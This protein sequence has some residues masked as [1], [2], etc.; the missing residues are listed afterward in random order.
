M[1]DISDDIRTSEPRLGEGEEDNSKANIFEQIIKSF[2]Y[3]RPYTSGLDLKNVTF[4]SSQGF[5]FL[6][7][8]IAD[9]NF[10]EDINYSLVSGLLFDELQDDFLKVLDKTYLE[11]KNST[12]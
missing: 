9:I 7:E 1:K 3:K 2:N 8:K 6:C 10:R 11:L 12:N 4:G 5:E